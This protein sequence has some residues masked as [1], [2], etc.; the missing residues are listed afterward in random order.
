LQFAAK[1]QIPDVILLSCDHGWPAAQVLRKAKWL[2]YAGFAIAASL[3][4]G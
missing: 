2:L 3:D 1:G 4:P